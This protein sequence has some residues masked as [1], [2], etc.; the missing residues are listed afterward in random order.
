MKKL[1]LLAILIAVSFISLAQ[2]VG[3]GTTTPDAKL[4][5]ADTVN[6]AD[7][8]VG[9]FINIHNSS[10]ISPIGVMAGIRFRLD[11]VNTGANSRYK[12]GIFFQKTASFAV[13]S[14]HFAVN[15][16]GNNNNVTAA[17]AKMTIASNGRVGIG[18]IT[19]SAAL[20]VNTTVSEVTRIQGANPYIS[21]HDNT[22]GY[23]GYLW[24]NG[25]DMVLGGATAAG[26]RFSTNSTYRGAILSD[27]RWVIGSGLSAG[28]GYLLSVDGKVIVE[29]ARVQLSGS[30]P[31]YVFSNNYKLPSIS[32]LAKYVQKNKHLPNM[33]S[34][35]EVEKEKGFDLGDMQKRM[36]EKVEE[37]TLYVIQ[38]KKENDELQKRV[39][40]LEKK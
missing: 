12:G 8:T 36:L 4:H 22:D 35:A 28:T 7:G 11:G 31:D 26:I 21:F 29:E 15:D 27:G 20:H 30:W 1:M 3:I 16:D 2:N 6:T 23:K 19:P 34:A 38:L 10:I 18:T 5:V 32:E 9:A 24:Y 13:G 39:V 40:A 37:L 25:T 14:L 17:D 33:P